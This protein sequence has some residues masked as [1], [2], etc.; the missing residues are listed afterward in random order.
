M[1]LTSSKEQLMVKAIENQD[2][3]A[4]KILIKDLTE[5]QI[6]MICKSL[7]PGNENQCT[8]LHYATWQGMR[9]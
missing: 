8:I 4:V 6:R 7:V 1:G 3:E 5:E 9:H 2:V